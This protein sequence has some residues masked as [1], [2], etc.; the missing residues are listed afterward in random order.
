M[1]DIAITIITVDR[2]PRR[3]YLGQ[4]AANFIRGGVFD[5]P[6]F[7]SLHIADS[8]GHEGWPDRGVERLLTLVGPKY[9]YRWIRSTGASHSAY[10]YRTA[11][12]RT[13]C[14]NASAALDAG[15]ATDAQW[16]LFCEDD[17]DVCGDFLDSVGRWLDIYGDPKYHVFPFGAAYPQV[18]DAAQ[19]LE[20]FWEYPVTKFYGTQCFAIRRPEAQ[21]L[22]DYWRVTPKVVGVHS[23]GAFD[24]MLAEWHQQKFPEQPYL[25][26]SAPSF[27]QHIGRDS[28]AT[29]VANTHQ[30]LSWPGPFWTFDPEVVRT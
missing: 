2:T 28:V 29:G 16:I 23:P 9:P 10:V 12:A 24:L 20:F 4:T 19:R 7:H 8:G 26:A 25:L 11:T 18:K 17:L 6:R 13:A 14:V 5:S 30:F 22:S 3:N 15:M 1:N 21:S 27:V